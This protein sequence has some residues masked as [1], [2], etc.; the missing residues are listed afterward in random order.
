M[1]MSQKLHPEFDVLDY[2]AAK[3][4]DTISFHPS[5]EICSQN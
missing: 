3:K 5:N 2:Y 4:P 1:T